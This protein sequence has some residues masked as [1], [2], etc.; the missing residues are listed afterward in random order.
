MEVSLHVIE[1]LLYMEVL[2]MEVSLHVIGFL[3]MEVLYMEVSLH[4]TEVSSIWR[5]FIWRF[6]CMY[7][8]NLISRRCTVW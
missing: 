3:Y 6:H 1:V 2:Y 4:V 8:L 5:S 7:S